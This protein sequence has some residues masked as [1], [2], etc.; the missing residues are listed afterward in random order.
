MIL[1]YISIRLQSTSW[2]RVKTYYYHV[3]GNHR[4][5]TS[6]FRFILVQHLGTILVLT[7]SNSP[8]EGSEKRAQR[9]GGSRSLGRPDD[10]GAGKE[11]PMEII[12][13]GPPFIRCQLKDENAV[14]EK[15][16]QWSLELL[17]KYVWWFHRIFIQSQCVMIHNHFLHLNNPTLPIGLWSLKL[18]P[19]PCAVLLVS[20]NQNEA[21]VSA[22]FRWWVGLQAWHRHEFLETA[23]RWGKADFSTQAWLR[24]TASSH[25]WSD[26]AGRKDSA[27]IQET[28]GAEGAE[29]RAVGR[30]ADLKKTTAWGWESIKNRDWSWGKGTICNMIVY[31][32]IY[33]I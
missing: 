23:S 21:E 30:P 13:G 17:W 1:R 6:Y 33:N 16:W 5:F 24:S 28:C 15:L 4:P 2:H 18:P 25:G 32:Y 22:A 11:L 3:W 9:A 29:S 26:L 10:A 12:L 20:V 31:T 14:M 27:A 19:P 8:F 7:T